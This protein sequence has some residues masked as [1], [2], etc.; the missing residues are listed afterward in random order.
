[1]ITTGTGSG[2][3]SAGLPMAAA[4]LTAAASTST[5]LGLP[6][7]I[8]LIVEAFRVSH[9]EAGF[10]VTALW[11][12]HA[13]SQLVGGWAATAGSP[14]RL[15]CWALAALAMAL[16]LT[17]LVPTYGALVGARALAGLATGASFTLCIV[18]AAAHAAPAR[19]RATQAFVGAMSYVGCSVVYAAIALTEGRAG[20]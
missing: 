18:Y 16:G 10:M 11:V 3:R 1:M 6:A 20:W 12:P 9:A 14:R 19:Q 4:A 17:L 7:V 8:P 13:V 5:I 2:G 15:L